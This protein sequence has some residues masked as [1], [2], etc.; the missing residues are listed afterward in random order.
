MAEERKRQTM[1]VKE[2]GTV[3]IEK[4]KKPEKL[5]EKDKPKAQD[6]EG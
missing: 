4:D 1:I 3:F 6:K 5:P 2:G